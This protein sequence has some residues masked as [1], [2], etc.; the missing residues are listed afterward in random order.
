M[1]Q[2]SWEM[3]NSSS[4]QKVWG[5]L[6]EDLLLKEC[7]F[8]RKTLYQNLNSAIFYLGKDPEKYAGNDPEKEK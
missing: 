6:F 4:I 7:I 1:S 5:F 3:S 2:E 8:S